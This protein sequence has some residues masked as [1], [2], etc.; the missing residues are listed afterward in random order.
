MGVS[1]KMQSERTSEAIIELRSAVATGNVYTDL[2]EIYRAAKEGRGDLLI[3]HYE[4]YQAVKMIDEFSFELVQN[5]SLPNVIDDIISMIAW[6]VISKNGRVLF[7]ENDELKEL[8][9]IV[10]KVR[11][12]KPKLRI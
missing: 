7:T 6:E 9:N 12:Y 10:L 4:Y 2:Q 8:G 1:K 5:A 11:Y 3:T